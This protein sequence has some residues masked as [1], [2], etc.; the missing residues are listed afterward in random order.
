MFAEHPLVGLPLTLF[1]RRAARA[2]P[3]TIDAALAIVA[4]VCATTVT[5]SL[6][7][8]VTLLR[9]RRMLAL[10]KG[11]MALLLLAAVVV[12]ASGHRLAFWDCGSLSV[13]G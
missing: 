5:L 8:A 10:V 7:P 11:Y 1:L 6:V 2:I 4:L 13:V 12:I 9:G 3:A